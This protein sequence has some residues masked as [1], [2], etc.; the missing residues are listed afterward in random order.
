MEQGK[1]HINILHGLLNHQDKAM[2]VNVFD[3]KK[4]YPAI[5]LRCIVL[6][7]QTLLRVPL[8]LSMRW[9]MNPVMRPRNVLCESCR[10]SQ[11]V[12]PG[13][14]KISAREKL[15]WKYL[16]LCLIK[17]KSYFP[18]QFNSI[19]VLSLPPSENPA[20][21]GNSSF[22]PRW[23]GHRN[24]TQVDPCSQATSPH[25]SH[26]ALQSVFLQAEFLWWLLAPNF[27]PHCSAIM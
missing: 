4:P 23:T 5:L 16:C 9:L 13:Q 10:L 21:V 15:N 18:C 6:E 3:R 19:Y 11:E 25:T 22:G 2:S 12:Q 20:V 1:S 8:H 24:H 27:C 17:A 14:P 7:V 26:S